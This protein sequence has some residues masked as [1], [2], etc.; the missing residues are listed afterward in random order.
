M[1]SDDVMKLVAGRTAS[2]VLET[3]EQR[4]AEN[5]GWSAPLTRPLS[6]FSGARMELEPR[7]GETM[8]RPNPL[9]VEL[10]QNFV[11]LFEAGATRDELLRFLRW[12][13]VFP[14]RLAKTVM[15]TF[16]TPY[17]ARA[18]VR[19]VDLLNKADRES[20]PQRDLELARVNVAASE[21]R[22]EMLRPEVARAR[23]Y[24][25]KIET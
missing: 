21:R 3:R 16:A 6:E 8:C 1:E 9:M 19:E 10:Q 2:Q 22:I 11:N 23:A 18:A 7:P 20:K 17:L 5:G 15:E 4:R 25:A 14:R 24:L 13:T 12:P